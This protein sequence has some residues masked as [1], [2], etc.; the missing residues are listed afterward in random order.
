MFFIPSFTS[1]AG[2]NHVVV[3]SDLAGCLA[4][5]VYLERTDR[6]QEDVTLH[7]C[8]SQRLSVSFKALHSLFGIGAMWYMHGDGVNGLG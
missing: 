3:P 1:S 2:L 7:S 4:Q 5:E 8:V 6:R